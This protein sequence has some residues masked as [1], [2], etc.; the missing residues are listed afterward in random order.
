[1]DVRLDKWLWAARL[2]KTRSS[3]TEAIAA[4]HVDLNDRRAKAGKSVKVNDQIV[5]R[6][7]PYHFA[8]VVKAL[9]ERRGSATDAQALYEESADSVR[10]RQEVAARLKADRVDPFF[11]WG[12]GRPTKKNRRQLSK[13]K[14]E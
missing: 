4:G 13:L 8:L 1:M 9:A 14:P 6:K 10:A 7:G 12:K 11:R 5:V 3:A 2:Y